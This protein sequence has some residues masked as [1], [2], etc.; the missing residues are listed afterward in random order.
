VDSIFAN[1]WEQRKLGELIVKG[2]SGGTPLASNTSYYD[3]PIHFLGISDI[4]GRY[5]VKTKKMISELGLKNS[6]AWIVPKGAL[7]LA[8]YASVGV[9]GICSINTATSQ[10]FYNMIFASDSLRDFVFTRLE[11]ANAE[12]EWEPL[13]STGTQRNLNAE[14]VRG[15]EIL[16]PSAK[17]ISNIASFFLAL[18]SSIVLHQRE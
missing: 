5:I 13:I 10:A 18:D 8:M 2:G 12:K 3:G 9:V 11:K 7:S 15:F 14:K 16:V 6:A 4:D 17:E 1:T